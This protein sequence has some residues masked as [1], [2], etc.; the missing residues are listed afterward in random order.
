M[1]YVQCPC[2][3]AFLLGE[4]NIVEQFFHPSSLLGVELRK[5]REKDKGVKG[6]GEV[7][8]RFSLSLS[9]NESFDRLC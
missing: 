4:S 1:K 5:K 2:D 9:V 8:H 3:T 6:E 7:G